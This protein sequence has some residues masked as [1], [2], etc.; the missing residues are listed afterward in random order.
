M[1]GTPWASKIK[2]DKRVRMLVPDGPNYL[3]QT[4]RVSVTE[5]D[6]ETHTMAMPINAEPKN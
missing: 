6:Q 4:V 2:A 1:I 3:H 5:N